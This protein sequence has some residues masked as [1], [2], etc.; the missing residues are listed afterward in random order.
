MS[1][2]GYICFQ[3]LYF[4]FFKVSKTG[5]EKLYFLQTCLMTWFWNWS[6]EEFNAPTGYSA[7]L[8]WALCPPFSLSSECT[9]S[10][11]HTH[12]FFFEYQ[13]CFCPSPNSGANFLKPSFKFVL[14][15]LFWGWVTKIER[16]FSFYIHL[17]ASTCFVYWRIFLLQLSK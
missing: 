16:C 4:W 6:V 14:C 3:F 13:I 9:C 12:I 11:M 5:A 1:Y 2:S 8:S 10:Y 17:I 7:I 15:V